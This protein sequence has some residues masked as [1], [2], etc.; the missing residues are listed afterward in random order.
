MKGE[1]RKHVEITVSTNMFAE[2]MVNDEKR[3]D[4]G[5]QTPGG[6]LSVCGQH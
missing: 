3:E 4:P 2:I 6:N 1:E 5:L